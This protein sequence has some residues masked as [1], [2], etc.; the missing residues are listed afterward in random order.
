MAKKLLLLGA[1]GSAKKA[2]EI[3][4][5]Q[6]GWDEIALLD[7]FPDAD[8]LCSFPIIGKCDDVEQYR[9]DYTHAFICMA[10][11]T[12]RQHFLRKIV[13]GGFEV[14]NIIHPLAYISPSAKLGRGIFVNPF[15]VIQ[16]D[17]RIG[18]GCIINTGAI[19][20]HDNV[21]GECVNL[22]PN[23]TTTGGVVIGGCSFLGAGSC[24]INNIR[25]GKNVMVAAGAVVIADLPD[26]VMAAGCP[27][28]IKKEITAI[29][30]KRNQIL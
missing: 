19:V 11:C 18:D 30:F 10:G 22:S 17:C 16:S 9:Q 29:M 4:A 5:G 27:A 6:D 21:L 14:P 20:E 15:S 2:L 24:V 26:N 1:K 3:L 13:A 25:I 12:T 28:V 8:E 23:A 7:N